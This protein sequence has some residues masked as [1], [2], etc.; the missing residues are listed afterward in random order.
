MDDDDMVEIA[1]DDNPHDQAVLLLAAADDLGL[2]PSVV[3]TGSGTFVVPKEV[4]D[5]AKPKKTAR[6][7]SKE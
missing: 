3:R 4:A 6:K 1:F 7:S 2:D 5:K